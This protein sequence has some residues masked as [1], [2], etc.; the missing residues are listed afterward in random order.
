MEGKCDICCSRDGKHGLNLQKCMLCGVCVHETCYGC[1]STFK[2][3]VNF[4]CSACLS[5]GKAI[6]GIHLKTKERHTIVQTKRPTECALCSVDNGCHAMH[7]VFHSSGPKGSHLVLPAHDNKE[8]RLAWAHSLCAQG[9]S[10]SRSAQG[11]VYACDVWGRFEGGDG[12]MEGNPLADDDDTTILATHHYVICGTDGS[13]D[14]WT[15]AIKQLRNNLKCI[16]CGCN[17]KFSTRI[18]IQCSAGDN[19]ELEEFKCKHQAMDS[20]CSQALHVGC[21]AWKSDGQFRQMMFFPGT[22]EGN[23]EDTYIEPVAEI[24]CHLHA[25]EIG[26]KSLHHGL[27]GPSG[28]SHSLTKRKLDESNSAS[29]R[30]RRKLHASNLRYTNVRATP[31]A[32]QSSTLNGETIK[33]NFSTSS[34]HRQDINTVKPK[35]QLSAEPSRRLSGISKVAA[36]RKPSHSLM[37]NTVTGF[38]HG[39]SRARNMPPPPPDLEPIERHSGGRVLNKSSMQRQSSTAQQKQLRL[40]KSGLSIPT[41]V[42]DVP[43]AAGII[44]QTSIPTSLITKHVVQN[45]DSA[46]ISL[47]RKRSLFDGPPIKRRHISEAKCSNDEKCHDWFSD[48]IIDVGE[49]IDTAKKDDMDVALVVSERRHFWKKKSGILSSSFTDVWKQVTSRFEDDLK[50]NEESKLPHVLPSV[51]SMNIDD[52]DEP[53]EDAKNKWDILWESFADPFEIGTWDFSEVTFKK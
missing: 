16:I 34:L 30:R 13:T 27:N 53:N 46:P 33:K 52:E 32:E 36:L 31:V 26:K 14:D 39:S 47:P 19:D 35:R 44:R 21:A 15:K 17:D 12:L 50:A 42:I 43:K 38:K 37:K 24:Y 7:P 41:Q 20:P 25:S 6:T 28:K 45:Q 29:P 9:I 23:S 22:S 51:I 3:D 18:P 10:S 5:I 8:E 11:C 40:E 2:K 49:T 4:L 1:V 48:M